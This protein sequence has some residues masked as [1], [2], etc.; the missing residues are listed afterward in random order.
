MF[1]Y[2]VRFFGVM[3]LMVKIVMF[4]GNIVF[5]VLMYC[6]LKVDDGNIFSVCVFVLSVVKVLVVVV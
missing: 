2:C 5:N 1:I 3:L 6:G 4:D